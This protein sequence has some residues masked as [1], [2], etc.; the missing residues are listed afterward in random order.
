M[1]RTKS[2]VIYKLRF[3]QEEEGYTPGHHS[4]KHQ[5]PWWESSALTGHSTTKKIANH[6]LI[7]PFYSWNFCLAEAFLGKEFE[8]CPFSLLWSSEKVVKSPLVSTS[9]AQAQLGILNLWYFWSFHTY[10]KPRKLVNVALWILFSYNWKFSL[11]TKFQGILLPGF[12]FLS[13]DWVIFSTHY[14]SSKTKAL[15]IH[16]YIQPISKEQ[17]SFDRQSTEEIWNWKI[18]NNLY[19]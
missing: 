5:E 9:E 16:L 8:I 19:F 10:V 6:F 3:T 7:K 12:L 17:I 1:C 14:R 13:V 15:F 4:R 11:G 18:K 2:T